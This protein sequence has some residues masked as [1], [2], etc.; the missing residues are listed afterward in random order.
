MSMKKGTY[1]LIIFLFFFLLAVAGF[2]FFLVGE[3]GRTSVDVPAHAYLEVGLSGS[4][5]EIAPSDLLSAILLRAKPLTIYDLWMNLRKAAADSRVQAVLLRLDLLQCDWAKATEMRDAVL[6]FRRS[7][8]KAYAYIEEA[9]DFD[10]EYYI[11]TACDKIVLH[12]LGWLGVNGIGGYVPFF[13]NALDKLGVRAEFEH[14]EEYKTAYNTFTE[15]GFTPAHREEMESLYADIFAQYVKTVA[16]ARGKTED[17]VRALIDR[18]FFQGEQALKAG[19]V[20]ACLFEDELQVLLRDRGPGLAR[21]RFEDYTR[22]TPASVGLETGRKV[23][24]VYAVGTIMTGESLPRARIMGGS[25]VARWIRAAREDRSI[26]AIVL[27][28]DSPGGSSVGSDVVWREVFLAKKAKPVVVSMSDVAGSGGYWISMAATRIVAEP[29]SLTGSIGVLAGKFSVAGLLD[30]LG[31]T[32]EKL[33]FGEK[34]DVFSPFRPFTPEERKAL[35]DQIL[36]TYDRFLTKVADG[37]SL[38]KAE[39]DKVGRGRVWTGRQAKDLKLVDELGGLSTA[40]GLAKKLAGIATEE[41]IKLIVWPKRLSFW[42]SFFGVPDLGIN[43]KSAAGLEKVL[44]TV[45]LMEKT[46]I[47]AVMPFWV[48]PN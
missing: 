29:Q 34:A 43:L 22:V 27:R 37:R 46:R 13:K 4:V 47:W 33:T 7:G 11:A 21:V 28:V 15:K 45:R 35:K 41:E 42:Q 10:M 3:F 8:K 6:Q 26:A 9:P 39:V 44:R 30:K 20:D 38:T 40:V 32:A 18:G 23:A 2:L 17:E 5:E 48:T 31:I 12:P 24:L 1:V 36:W 25:T 16:K 19:L 14:V